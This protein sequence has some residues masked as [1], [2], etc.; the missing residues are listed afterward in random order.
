MR[1]VIDDHKLQ[2]NGILTSESMGQFKGWGWIKQGMQQPLKEQQQNNKTTVHSMHCHFVWLACTKQIE[3]PNGFLECQVQ[4]FDN[5][6]LLQTKTLCFK[7][8]KAGWWYLLLWRG[9]CQKNSRIMHTYLPTY[10]HTYLLTY[11][12]RL[13]NLNVKKLI[14]LFTTFFYKC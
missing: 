2:K 8:L 5:N 9:C 13:W 14:E 1:S 11:Y 3:E 10:I 6:K 4:V 12:Q 7:H